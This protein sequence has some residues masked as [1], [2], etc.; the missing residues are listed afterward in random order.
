MHRVELHYCIG[1]GSI[2]RVLIL[3]KYCRNSLL[4]CIHDTGPSLLTAFPAGM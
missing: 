2:Q 1:I 4:V 3:G